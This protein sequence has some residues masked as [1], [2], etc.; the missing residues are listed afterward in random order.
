MSTVATIERRMRAAGLQPRTFR[1]A[2]GDTYG[3]H[4]HPRHKILFCVV[5]DI[6]FH[7]AAGDITLSTGDRLDLPPGT[8]H[9]ATVHD[10]GVVCVE[11]HADGPDDLP[12]PHT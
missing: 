8:E 10:G 12:Q 4:S 9:A 1:N 11:C 6:T 5:G 3:W 7:T 2:P